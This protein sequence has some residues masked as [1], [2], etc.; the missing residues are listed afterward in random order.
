MCEN[1]SRPRLTAEQIDLGF[2]KKKILPQSP[3]ISFI[4]KTC[5]VSN[6]S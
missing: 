1:S 2:S 5:A 6:I 3:E 4:E